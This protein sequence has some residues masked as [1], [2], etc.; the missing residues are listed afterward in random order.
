MSIQAAVVQAVKA[1]F[2]KVVKENP[3]TPGTYNLN[4]Q[5]LIIELSGSVTKGEDESYTP[6][7]CIPVTAALMLAFEKLGCIGPAFEN[8]LFSA[9]KEALE[10]DEKANER[11]KERLKAVAAVE[12][13]LQRQL[14]DLPKKTRTGKFLA[15]NASISGYRI[16]AGELVSA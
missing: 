10:A 16:E 2:A 8:M 5:R 7:V 11:I 13:R 12:E 14:G 1:K 6:T 4:G 15:K 3:L 9:M